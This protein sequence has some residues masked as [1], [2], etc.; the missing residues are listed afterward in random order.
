MKNEK[1]IYKFFVKM[2][3]I[4]VGLDLLMMC[5]TE[6]LASSSLFAK[7]GT[8]VIYEI[9]YALSILVVMLLFHNSYVFTEKKKKFWNSIY[10]GLPMLAYSIITFIVNLF[11]QGSFSISNC[12]NVFVLCLFVGIAEEFLCRGWLQNEFI[13]RFSND[14]NSVIKSIILSSLVFGV[15]H[16]INLSEQTVFETILQIIN[17][18]SVGVLLGSIY[19]KTKNI[20]SVIFLHAFYDFSIFLGEMNLIK[21]CTYATPSLSVGILEFTSIII[22]SV[23]WIMS[24]LKVLNGIKER[25]S[26][27][28]DT[29]YTS[30]IVLTFILAFIP[31]ERIVP[32]YDDYVICYDYNETEMLKNYEI[33]FPHYQEHF[34]DSTIKV[35][36]FD[37]DV[38]SLNEIKSEENIKIS[39]NKNW[40]GTIIIENELINYKNKLDIKEVKNI[41]ILENDDYYLIIIESEENEATIYYSKINKCDLRNSKDFMDYL[42]NSF[43]KYDLPEL[44]KIGYVT[45]LNNSLKHP[46]FVSSN[47][48]AFIIINDSLYLIK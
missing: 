44:S 14:R 27:K 6:L 23:L 47:N 16:I 22:L 5:V 35:S 34:I 45:F 9:F 30:I 38:N 48:D 18:V 26:K 8:D 33:H 41:E 31:F 7:Y 4:F 32:E 37:D 39:F 25:T 46:Y 29:I 43:K 10:L 2:L 40:D 13:E 11:N 20:W 1:N 15:M 28:K 17:A 24:A 12:I 21:D 42:S 3:L 19:Y 36:R